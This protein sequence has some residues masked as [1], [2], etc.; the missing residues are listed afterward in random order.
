MSSVVESHKH[1]EPMAIPCPFASAINTCTEY[2]YRGSPR[3]ANWLLGMIWWVRGGKRVEH[4]VG[5]VF[6]DHYAQGHK[7]YFRLARYANTMNT[8]AASPFSLFLIASATPLVCSGPYVTAAAAAPSAPPPPP[9]RSFNTLRMI[10]LPAATENLQG[11][12][13]YAKPSSEPGKIVR[14]A[15]V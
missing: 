3:A 10:S 12:K 8:T 4:D 15:T 9:S 1:R 13:K 6:K 7:G 11:E 2:L 14:T 5:G